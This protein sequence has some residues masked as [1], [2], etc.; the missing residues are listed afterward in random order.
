MHNSETID[1][2]A[3]AFKAVLYD[4]NGFISVE[5]E[6]REDFAKKLAVLA[7][8]T[9]QENPNDQVTDV[10]QMQQFGVSEDGSVV[11]LQLAVKED[12]GGIYIT[13]ASEAIPVFIN[14]LTQLMAHLVHIK[15][16]PPRPPG[17]ASGIGQWKVGRSNDPA[18][19]KFTAILF[20]EGTPNEVIRVLADIDALRI[21]DA[22]ETQVFA[23]LSQKDQ[24]D[25][26]QGVAKAKANSALILPPRLRGH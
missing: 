26:I 19:A 20:D 25:L 12:G 7:L 1:R 22:I 17:V 6:F 3:A 9:V 10:D 24:Q 21:A 11:R 23:G 15:A 18:L 4:A 2:L 14:G 16:I 8:D 5:L 13:M